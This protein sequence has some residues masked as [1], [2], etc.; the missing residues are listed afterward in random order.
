M[1][2][3]RATK[4]GQSIRI[5]LLSDP[6]YQARRLLRPEGLE[7]VS[8]EEKLFFESLDT[9]VLK[10]D[11]TDVTHIVI[12]G[13]TGKDFSDAQTGAFNS[14]R[15]ESYSE[16]AFGHA[17]I[18]EVIKRGLVSIDGNDPGCPSPPL[19]PVELLYGNNGYGEYWPI[20]MYEIHE[21]IK[22]WSSMGESSGSRSAP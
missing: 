14:I 8:A 12:K 17:N 5:P 16:S 2:F 19:Y 9:S 3:K 15:G 22:I 18:L 7:V 11:L 13:L 10:T 6:D 1:A 4:A 20:I 21:R